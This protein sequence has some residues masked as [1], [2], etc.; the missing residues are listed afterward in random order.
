MGVVGLRERKKLDTR[1]AIIHATRVLLGA[2]GFV[3]MTVDEIA[4]GAGVSPRTFFNYFSCKEEA[5]AAI[6]PVTL[7]DLADELRNRPVEES[8]VEALR[9]VL[10]GA[11]DTHATLE[12]WLL[13]NELVI[14][15][16]ELVPYHLAAMAQVESA[17]TQALADRVALDPA[18]D[19]RVRMLVATVMGATRA[20][21]VWWHDSDRERPL[22]LVMDDAFDLIA[23]VQLDKPRP[24]GIRPAAPAD[25]Q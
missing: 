13:R 12:R 19:P 14:E 4:D 2:R 24:L 5:A 21:I 3:R 10:I 20:G 22:P 1:R 6:D 15:H 25:H 7:N 17:L 23:P 16:P 11:S 18:H 9:A 8:P